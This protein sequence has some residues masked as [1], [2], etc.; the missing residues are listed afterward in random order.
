[1]ELSHPLQRGSVPGAR[2]QQIVELFPV[3]QNSDL[4][5]R[6]PRILRQLPS[7]PVFVLRLREVLH[8]QFVAPRF[9]RLCC[10]LAFCTT[11]R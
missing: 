4:V 9:Q 1:M 5:I 11:L 3:Q 6:G 7:A 10:R 8:T 2:F